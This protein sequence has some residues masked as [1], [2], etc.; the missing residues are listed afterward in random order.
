M[1]AA[2]ILKACF[3]ARGHPFED[4]ALESQRESDNEKKGG[5]G[6]LFSFVGEAGTGR[7]IKSSVTYFG[8]G[9]E[10][11]SQPVGSLP[12]EQIGT[13]HQCQP[14]RVIHVLRA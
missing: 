12:S 4:N 7:V 8:S 6:Q 13:T 10:V 2:Y 5:R 1:I 3:L 11:M 9:G 14:G